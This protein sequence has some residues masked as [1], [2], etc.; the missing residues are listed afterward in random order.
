[1]RFP[2]A[3]GNLDTIIDPSSSNCVNIESSESSPFR[4]EVTKLSETESCVSLKEGHDGSRR[5][6]KVLR[7]IKRGARRKSSRLQIV[8]YIRTQL[9][10]TDQPWIE[11]RV[12]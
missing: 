7:F 12:L 10:C 1:M 8:P 5:A 2:V 9:P 6:Y 4:A 11:D 3:W